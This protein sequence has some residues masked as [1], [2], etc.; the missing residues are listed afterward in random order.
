MATRPII[1]PVII[2][3][4]D[5]K[6]K[7]LHVEDAIEPLQLMLQA[8]LRALEDSGVANSQRRKLQSS[9]DS[10]NVI[11]TWT[12]PYGDLP[13]LLSQRLGINPKRREYSK[14]GGNQPIK[15]VDEAAR[16]ISRG[17]SKVAIV[18]GGE[19]LASCKQR[20][21]VAYL[22]LNILGMLTLV[23]DDEQ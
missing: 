3:I 20:R 13:G 10:L 16:R 15:L 19:A 21:I 1:T 2:G 7:S 11:A 12:W 9:I 4:G 8:S 17:E 6:N 22:D 18:T 14:Y 5:V 23:I